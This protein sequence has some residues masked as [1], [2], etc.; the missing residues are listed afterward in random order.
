MRIG[1]LQQER[2]HPVP[3]PGLSRSGLPGLWGPT[4]SPNSK[5]ITTEAI[6]CVHIIPHE[7]GPKHTDSHFSEH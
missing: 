3:R 4:L 5:L 1:S 7:W 2:L 6:L